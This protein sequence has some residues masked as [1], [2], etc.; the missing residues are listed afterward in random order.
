MWQAIICINDVLVTC[1][2]NGLGV[3]NTKL[4]DGDIT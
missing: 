3:L 1:G 4:E 2:S